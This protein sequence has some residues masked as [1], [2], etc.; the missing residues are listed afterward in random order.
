MRLKAVLALL[1]LVPAN[2]I[3]V[4]MALFI[5]PG[6]W[7]NTAFSLCKIWMLILP[8][9]WFFRIE[10]EKFQISKP[11]R[12]EIGVGLILG[13]LIFAVIV[14]AYWLLGQQWIDVEQTQQRAQAVGIT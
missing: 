11:T 14:G 9:I 7:G 13:F 2:S 4:T 5:A 1:L 12:R 8:A 3:G 10:R 6:G